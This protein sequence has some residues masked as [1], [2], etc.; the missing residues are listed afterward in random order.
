MK[1]KMTNSEFAGEDKTFINACNMVTEEF[2]KMKNTNDF[3]EFQATT[4]QASKWRMKKGIAY[5]TAHNIPLNLK[6]DKPK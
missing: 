5:K 3:T 6:E 1:I 2:P 4:R